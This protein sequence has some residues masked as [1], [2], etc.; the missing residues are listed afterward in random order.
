MKIMK[1]SEFATLQSGLVL[2]RKEAKTENEPAILYNRLNLR[3]LNEYGEIKSEEL[4]TFSSKALLDDSCLTQKGDVVV[5]LSVPLFPVLIE[6][7]S[8]NL[9]IPSQLAVIRIF[10][11]KV[12]PEYVRYYLSTQTASQFIMSFEA[13]AALHSIKINTLADLKIPIPPVEKQKLIV[14]I[15]Q[16]NLKTEQLYKELIK[17][18]SR[19]A[20][21]EIQKYLGGKL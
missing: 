8:V 13:G 2:S 6:E 12:L 19:L 5:K 14:N 17:Q 18:E 20:T 11:K 3:S 4:D 10:D 21:A 16:T 9:V 7:N 15:A 1:L